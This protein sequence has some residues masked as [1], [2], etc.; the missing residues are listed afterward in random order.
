MRRDLA[1]ACCG[2]DWW[3]T[4]ICP[5]SWWKI[6][7]LSALT[8]HPQLCLSL[9][10]LLYLEES[11]YS[12]FPKNKNVCSSTT[13]ADVSLLSLSV[14]SGLFSHRCALLS[15]TDPLLPTY[16]TPTSDMDPSPPSFT[17]SFLPDGSDG[18]LPGETTTSS[19]GS[20]RFLGHGLN[21]NLIPIYCSILAAVVVGFVAYIVFKRSVEKKKQ[22]LLR[23]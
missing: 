10:A 13:S 22:L 8:T 19:A 7:S 14:V 18:P 21:E 17:N 9:T 12:L 20:P 3:V 23:G 11:I 6:L 5:P 16:F 1:Q 15:H 4:D 2:V